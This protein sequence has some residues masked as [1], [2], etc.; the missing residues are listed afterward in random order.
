LNPLHQ[1]RILS[2]S[3][4]T[5]PP[6]IVDGDQ[7]QIRDLAQTSTRHLSVAFTRAT[8]TP[9]RSGRTRTHAV[10]P[11]HSPAVT[12]AEVAGLGVR[13]SR[14]PATSASPERRSRR[15]ERWA[16]RGRRKATPLI[17]TAEILAA[18]APSDGSETIQ[19][20][21]VFHL[22]STPRTVSETPTTP[23]GR[24]AAHPADIVGAA[25]QYWPPPGGPQ[26]VGE[27]A[28]AQSI[29]SRSTEHLAALSPSDIPISVPRLC[30]LPVRPLALPAGMASHE[31]WMHRTRRRG[32][33]QR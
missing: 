15:G 28:A 25:S 7:V 27:R 3:R 4:A 19:G 2:T 20:W 6:A 14:Q 10:H 33:G 1:Q 5:V 29:A 24:A 16:A 22:P 18:Y 8:S 9:R 26:A 31:R 30:L 32:R 12:Q 21:T 17:I 11:P 23:W 13:G